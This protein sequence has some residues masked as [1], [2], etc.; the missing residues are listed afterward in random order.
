MKYCL[1]SKNGMLDRLTLELEGTD[2]RMAEIQSRVHDALG[3][4]AEVR[5]V[6]PGTL[7]RFE[8]KATRLID[9]RAH[10]S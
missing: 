7:P 8:G 9:L 5:F 10:S 3:L 4:Q 6:A 1:I 2:C